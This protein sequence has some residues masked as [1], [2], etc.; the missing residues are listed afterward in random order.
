[1]AS[2]R[3]SSNG[4][5]RL[6][7]CA[8]LA[9]ASHIIMARCSCASGAMAAE[10]RD[11]VR[12][13][14]L[15]I[16]FDGRPGPWNAITDVPGVEVGHA[17]LIEG[18]GQ[19]EVGKGPVRTGVTA[20]LPLGKATTDAVTAGWFSFNGV[21][22]TIGTGTIGT[23]LIG[24]RGML[25]GPVMLTNTLSVGT[26]RQ[27]AVEWSRRQVEDPGTPYA[28]SRPVVA[29][30]WDGFLNDVEGRHLSR[31]HIFRALDS[32]DNGPV[33]E[34]NV[35]GGTGICS[36]DLK[37]GIGTSSRLVTTQ[38]GRFNIGVLVQSSFGR[39]PRLR[40]A[41]VPVGESLT[42]LMPESPAAE[43]SL[44]AMTA[45]GNSVIVVIA[46]DAPL[47]AGQLDRIARRAT[48]AI[49]RSGGIGMDGSG[50]IFLA[51]S[52]ANRLKAEDSEVNHLRMIIDINPLF[53]ATVQATE[54]AVVNA[55]VA[56]RTMEGIN[57]NVAHA[58]PH[59]R[60]Q[61]VLRRFNRFQGPPQSLDEILDEVHKASFL[62]P[63]APG[64]SIFVTE[65]YT[66]RSLLR[67]PARAAIFLT[68]ME[69]RGS[70]WDVPVEG[71]NALDMAAR[72]GFFAYTTDWLGLGG[73]Y[74]PPDGTKID[75]RTNAGPVSELVDHIRRSRK[76]DKID[77]V[78]EGHGGEVVSVLASDSDR[79]RSVVMT[80]LYYSEQ[81]PAKALFTPQFK[82]FLESA[83][84]GYRVFNP[85]EMTLF[86]VQDQEI[87]DYVF[88]S[89]KDL[90]VPVGPFLE[91]YGPGP[92]TTTAKKSRVS[93]LIISP[94]FNG[95]AAPGDMENLEADWAGG[96]KLVTL[97]GNYHV[98]RMEAPEIAE[99]YF[100]ELF[101]FL[102]P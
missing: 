28:H 51:F 12:A 39:R 91:F 47:L 46:T 101:G 26:A 16:A 9:L 72:R 55:L 36:F 71:R 11:G 81:G 43:Q 50:D 8:A 96:A 77:L 88:A 95:W 79:I 70:F 27:A 85:M 53:E 87:R 68:A 99:R 37:G 15:G 90:E 60:L 41:G 86:H 13:R 82:D 73:S 30:T 48:L 80:N 1:M 66:V 44:A 17:T 24:E 57:G 62:L 3:R 29:G 63:Y 21:G 22:G 49:G 56:A 69:Y 89:Q 40:I 33:A 75:Y 19:L 54:E 10:P 45:A 34:G 38:H 65:Y 100:R 74:R 5:R 4:Q 98:S 42:G 83:P 97:A 32:A 52:T 92:L 35:G 76:V 59:E 78:G 23:E 94:E 67:Q 102:D 14:D 84:A 2:T 20:I 18:E 6:L 93:A 64:K 25:I 7:A 31:Q 61:D 58:L